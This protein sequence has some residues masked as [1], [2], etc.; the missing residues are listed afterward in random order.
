MP[1]DEGYQALD[2]ASMIEDVA[3]WFNSSR[4]FKTPSHLQTIM[5]TMVQIAR[6]TAVQMVDVLMVVSLHGMPR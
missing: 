4:P 5:G 6:T 1:S 3:R 2:S